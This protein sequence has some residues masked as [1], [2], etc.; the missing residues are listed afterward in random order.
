MSNKTDTTPCPITGY[1]IPRDP[2]IIALIATLEAVLKQG[3]AVL[4]KLKGGH[5]T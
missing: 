4:E 2:D 5:I 3:E 1:D